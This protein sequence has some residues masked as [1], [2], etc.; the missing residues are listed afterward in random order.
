MSKDWNAFKRKVKNRQ[1]AMDTS[2]RGTGKRTADSHIGNPAELRWEQLQETLEEARESSYF[3][4]YWMLTSSGGFFGRVRLFFKKVIRK[5]L[6]VFLGWYLFPIYQRQS[7]CNGK[8]VNAVAL[9]RD[10]LAQLSQRVDALEQQ[11]RELNNTLEQQ[12]RELNNT[13]AEKEGRLAQAETQLYKMQE[14]PSDDDDFYHS[15]EEK[16][17]GSRDEIKARLQIYVPVVQEQLPDWS[18][19][20]FV[21][22]GSGRGEWLDILRDNGATDYVGIDL[23]QRQNAICESFGHPTICGDCLKY[24]EEQQD[25]SV[26]LVSGFQLIEHLTSSDFVKLLQEC[27]RVLKPGG[28]ILFETPNPN[29][30]VVAANTFY[31]DLSHKRPLHPDLAVFIAEWC[32]YK[33]AVA[34]NANAHPRWVSIVEETERTNPELLYQFNDIKW[35]LYGPQDYALFAIKE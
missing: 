19:R 34:I 24:L 29:N 27:Y 6:K 12:N 21:D 23:N 14:L 4:G 13:L 1:F 7:H 11:N 17:R 28:A 30:L 2:W 25:K 8:L 35:Q 16:F 5:L 15:F 33:G 32:G 3:D 18:A 22:L 10:L 26:D 31:F 9:E 20:R